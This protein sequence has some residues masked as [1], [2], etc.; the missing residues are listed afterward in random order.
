[1][2]FRSRK[3]GVW[4]VVGALAACGGTAVPSIADDDGGTT[5]RSGDGGSNSDYD[6]DGGG[7]QNQNDSGGGGGKDTGT[8]DTGGKS[9]DEL[10]AEVDRLR[11]GAIACSASDKPTPCGQL[12]D[13]LCCPL[14]VSDNNAEGA[15]TFR[16]AVK[17]YKDAN[18][19]A[20][21]TDIPCSTQASGKCTGLLTKTCTQ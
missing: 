9:C 5:L 19:K 4:L 2:L 11:P 15:R 12:I 13:D 6:G 20:I 17:N 8:P 3:P 18:C 21:C 1:M 7:G 16:A 14:T 10:K